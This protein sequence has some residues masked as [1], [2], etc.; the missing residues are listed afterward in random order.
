MRIRTIFLAIVGVSAA[1][2]SRHWLLPDVAAEPAALSKA[3]ILPL[4]PLKKDAIAAPAPVVVPEVVLPHGTFSEFRRLTQE[5]LAALPLTQEVEAQAGHDFHFSPPELLKTSPALGKIADTM[6]GH[7]E[8]V[9]Q[10]I[11]FY[12]TCAR[13]SEVL[14]GVRVVCLH[15]L[16]H[17]VKQQPDVAQ[18]RHEDYPEELWHLTESLPP[19]R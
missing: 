3:E 18:L 4:P 16:K 13:N 6:K 12:D 2:F 8:L 15:R 7:P 19:V 17:W 11:E 1:L 5:T 10:G 9:P 14:I